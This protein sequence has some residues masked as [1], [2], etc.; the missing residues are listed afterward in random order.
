MEASKLGSAMACVSPSEPVPVEA[1]AHR[2]SPSGTTAA[3]CIVLTEAQELSAKAERSKKSSEINVF[4][5]MSDPFGRNVRSWVAH[6]RR[7]TKEA[8]ERL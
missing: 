5:L 1:M 4:L 8:Y 2:I 7:I 6:I 3:V